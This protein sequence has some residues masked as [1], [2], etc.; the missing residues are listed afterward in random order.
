MFALAGSLLFYIGIREARENYHIFRNGIET[1][2]TVV[3]LYHRPMKV[4]EKTSGSK[5]PVIQFVTNQN[6][7]IRFYSTSFSN[8]SHYEIGQKLRIWYLPENPQKASLNGKDAWLLS[9]SFLVFGFVICLI[10]YPMLIKRLF[11]FL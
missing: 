10:F 2:G 7:Q 3:D 1:E 4:N 6:I 5:A 8:L 11:Q 9:A